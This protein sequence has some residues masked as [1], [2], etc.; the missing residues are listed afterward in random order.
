MPQAAEAAESEINGN[1]TPAMAVFEIGLSDIGQH[2]LTGDLRAE[3]RSA[4]SSDASPNPRRARVAASKG[5]GARA[6]ESWRTRQV[7]GRRPK[8]GSGRSIA[9]KPGCGSPVVGNARRAAP[10]ESGYAF[11][12]EMK[13]PR[14]ARNRRRLACVAIQ[15]RESVC[16]APPSEISRGGSPRDR[17][18]KGLNLCQVKPRQANPRRS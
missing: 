7:D 4:R 16:S 14:P 3:Y 8:R 10:P 2:R 9:R 17:S 13:L 11:H 5:A 15:S 6:L 12:I 18:E 1:E